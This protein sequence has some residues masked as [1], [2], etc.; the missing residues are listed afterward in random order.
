[1]LHSQKLKVKS[2][3]C[4]PEKTTEASLIRLHEKLNDN[5]M[6]CHNQN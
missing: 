4:I 1:M 6:M 3:L 2:F 5:E